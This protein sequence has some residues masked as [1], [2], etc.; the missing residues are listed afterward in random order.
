MQGS[1]ALYRTWDVELGHEDSTGASMGTS[2]WLLSFILLL[3]LV[4]VQPFFDHTVRS[5]HSPPH[6]SRARGA[7]TQAATIQITCSFIVIE[8]D[9][10]HVFQSRSSLL[11]CHSF[12]SSSTACVGTRNAY[13]KRLSAQ[14]SHLCYNSDL[15]LLSTS[16]IQVI[17]NGRVEG[18]HIGSCRHDMLTRLNI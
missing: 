13:L 14:S 12:W 3:F 17:F 1:H 15:C 5:A 4:G 6:T 18:I 8:V 10:Q 16:V 11:C 9:R 2:V 7:A